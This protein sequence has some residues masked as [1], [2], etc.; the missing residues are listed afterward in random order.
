[1]EYIDNQP[2]MDDLLYLERFC[3]ERTNAWLDAFKTLLVRFE[4]KVINWISWHYLAFASILIR[5]TF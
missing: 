1:M 5:P 2:L 4:T 3:V